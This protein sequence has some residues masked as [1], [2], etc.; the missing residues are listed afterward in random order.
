MW[1]C[2]RAMS[3]DCLEWICSRYQSRVQQAFTSEHAADLR[4]AYPHS[5]IRTACHAVQQRFQWRARRF[6]VPVLKVIC[7]DPAL[8]VDDR[9]HAGMRDAEIR[10]L[11]WCRLDL[12]KAVVTVPDSK[13]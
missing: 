11:Q 1:R 5:V 9:V 6:H 13:S 4:I 2:H 10:G 12:R 3:R 8:R 7:G